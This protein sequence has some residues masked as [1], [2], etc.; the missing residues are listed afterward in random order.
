MLNIF[1][2]ASKPKPHLIVDSNGKYYG[3]FPSLATARQ[4]AEEIMA[5]QEPPLAIYIYQAILIDK[6]DRE[7][8]VKLSDYKSS[9]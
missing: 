5:G 9:A 1:K 4:L 7:D 8:P 2:R 6:A 3:I